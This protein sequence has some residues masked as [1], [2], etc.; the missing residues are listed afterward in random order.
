MST[1]IDHV[2]FSENLGNPNQSQP[3]VATGYQ[4]LIALSGQQCIDFE[5]SP[6]RLQKSDE[7]SLL[8]DS[9]S[10]VETALSTDLNNLFVKQVVEQLHFWHHHFLAAADMKVRLPLSQQQWLSPTLS[11]ML[12]TLSQHLNWKIE[13]LILEIE[14][15]AL[16]SNLQ[17][18]VQQASQLQSLG[19]GVQVCEFFPTHSAIANIEYC[20]IQSV[21]LAQGVLRKLSAGQESRVF[22]EQ[23]LEKFFRNNIEVTLPS[24]DT[25]K[26]L[27]LLT[28]LDCTNW[29]TLCGYLMGPQDAT[30]LIYADSKI[31]TE[32]VTRYLSAMNR[33]S[34][35]VQGYLGA[36]MV[37]RYWDAACP[38]RDW[39][40]S[41]QLIRQQSGSFVAAND[42]CL[43]PEQVIDL[44]QW[45]NT[46]V[47]QG[48]RF[49]RDL[50]SLL[51]KHSDLTPDEIQLLGL[52]AKS[53]KN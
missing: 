1:S 37:R 46:F 15:S 10:L 51:L 17:W 9:T 29:K 31:A 43:S 39:L 40:T 21:K 4:S 7:P 8:S 5:A 20:N 11:A 18:S 52:Q 48:R 47:I 26:Q 23:V 34:Q 45:V 27:N 30:L 13:G 32:H 33:L 12:T 36:V 44:K 28:Q 6:A 25:P 38:Q 22:F 2:N 50:P 49:I 42:F 19:I 24:I 16:K 35:S 53:Q 3:G 14:Y 41:Q